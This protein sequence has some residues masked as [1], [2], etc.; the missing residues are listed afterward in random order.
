MS[1]SVKLKPENHALEL[2]GV[3]LSIA[4]PPPGI[5]SSRPPPVSLQLTFLGRHFFAGSARDLLL[6]SVSTWLI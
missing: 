5:I 4:L 3:S 1:F 6:V 2:L